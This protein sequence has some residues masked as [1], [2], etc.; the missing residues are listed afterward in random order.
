MTTPTNP[1]SLTADD[2][3][4][5]SKGTSRSELNTTLYMGVKAITG[6]IMD[7]P[8]CMQENDTKGTIKHYNSII[9]QKVVMSKCFYDDTDIPRNSPLLNMIITRYWTGKDGNINKPSLLHAMEG[10]SPF[11]MLDLRKYEVALLNTEDDLITS[12]SLARVAD[13]RQRKKTTKSMHSR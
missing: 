7:L 9:I 2:K 3:Q 11:T 6:D 4:E 13:Q 5:K 12:A 1:S 8:A 10:L